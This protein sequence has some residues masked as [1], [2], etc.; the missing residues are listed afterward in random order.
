MRTIDW[1]KSQISSRK[2]TALPIM[3]HPGIE[4]LGCK[5]LDAVTNG[6][7]HFK[8]MEALCKHFP[9]SEA[10]TVIMD[11]TVEAEAFGAKILFSDNEVP[12]IV[13]R[14]VSN[15]EEVKALQIP[16]LEVARVSDY[17]R[18]NH[19]AAKYIDKPTFAGCIG[20]YSL[21][22]RLYD[23]TEIMMAIYTE[24]KTVN[25]LLEKCTAFIKKYCQ[26]LKDMG[27][28]GVI[29]AE[30]A[31]GLLSNEDCTQYSSIYVK[32]IVDVVQDDDFAVILH[33][34]GNTGHCTQAMIDTGAMC[35]HFGNKADMFDALQKCPKDVLVM[36][37]LDPVGVFKNSTSEMVRTITL[38]LL[39]KT[40]GYPNFVIS[41]GCDTP[42]NVPFGNIAAFYDAIDEFNTSK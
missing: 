21:A 41:S 26:A 1:I 31:A 33:N 4:L 25:L 37:N 27:V 6:E 19:L 13:G 35:Y 28:A 23:M 15:Y 12:T 24:P 16:D 17:L 34:C 7:T 22:G 8:A 32:Q 39:N 29:M 11:L 2:V 42:P 20:P 18:A 30:P 5:V 38:D 9:Q 40:K 14:L 3:T 10:C 36:G